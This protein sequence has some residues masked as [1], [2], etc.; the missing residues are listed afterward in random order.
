MSHAA[1]ANPNNPA[2][3]RPEV[4]AGRWLLRALYVVATFFSAFFAA[5][6]VLMTGQFLNDEIPAGKIEAITG[7]TKIGPKLRLDTGREAVFSSQVLFQQAKPVELKPGDRGEKR[8]DSF[9][10]IVNG[11]ALTDLRW[12][13]QNWL[14]PVRLL[15][16]LVA[17][18]IVGTVYVLAYKRTP[19]GDCVWSDADPKRPRRPR[20]RAGL[21][22]AMLLTWLIVF[23]LVTTAFGCMAG[24]LSGIGKAIFE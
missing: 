9:V 21:I 6:G 7:H 10:Y 11:S 2:T 5:H 18:V 22:T 8:R 1:E 24:C 15:V 20:T 12:V 4:S 14:L 17:Y 19:L 23:G 3:G 13:R 16:P